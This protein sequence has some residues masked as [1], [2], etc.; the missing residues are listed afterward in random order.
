[1]AVR[2]AWQSGASA[3]LSGS[4]ETEDPSEAAR[5][6]TDDDWSRRAAQSEGEG[7]IGLSKALGW[8]SIALGIAE[9]AAPRGVARLIGVEDDTGNRRLL[10]A[11]GL[12][13]LATGIGILAQP[14]QPGWLWARVG[15][16][17]MDLALLGS[18]RKSDRAEPGRLNAATVAVLGVTALD[19]LTGQRLGSQRNGHDRELPAGRESERGIRVRRSVT[20]LRMPEEVYTFW[21]D[22][23][24]LPRFMEHLESVEV[25]DDRRSRWRAKAPVGT[26]VEWEAEIVEDTPNELITWRS[27]PGSEV[28]NTGSVKFVPAPGGRGTEI[29]VELRYDPPGGKL[30]ATIAKLFGEAPEQQVLSDLRRLKQVMETG[31][32]VHSDASIHRGPHPARPATEAKGST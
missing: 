8:F 18:A 24:N 10:Q 1:M 6:W 14:D 22:F 21:R 3:G 11:L 19:A 26:D 4:V 15:G 28:D 20:V 7:N 30:G 23:R 9:L 31:E 32:V 2:E 16:D 29:H 13:E 27:L 25:L 5:R 12:R 17:V